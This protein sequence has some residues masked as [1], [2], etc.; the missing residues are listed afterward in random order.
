M[1][2][3]GIN[4]KENCDIE[5]CYTVGKKIWQATHTEIDSYYLQCAPLPI[6]QKV[7]H[8]IQTLDQKAKLTPSQR[9]KRKV[10]TGK[11]QRR[12]KKLG[13]QPSVECRSRSSSTEGEHDSL[14]E[15]FN[16]MQTL[17][18]AAAHIEGSAQHDRVRPVTAPLIANPTEATSEASF[19]AEETDLFTSESL[20]SSSADGPS[21]HRIN[22]GLLFYDWPD[23]QNS[24]GLNSM[25]SGHHDIALPELCRDGVPL[26]DG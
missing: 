22:E 23:I 5:R 24:W 19:A 15:D 1:K 18:Y 10:Q 17:V 20:Q 3:R 25:I 12:R 16:R 9:P 11:S 26:F 21:A 6:V 8:S 13:S 4:N 2:T 14:G 7:S